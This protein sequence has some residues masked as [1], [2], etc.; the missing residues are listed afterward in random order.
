MDATIKNKISRKIIVLTCIALGV[1]A[2]IL[3]DYEHLSQDALA[4]IICLLFAT[5]TATDTLC[6]LKTEKIYSS[7]LAI[8]KQEQPILFIFVLTGTII[9]L[10]FSF[11]GAIYFASKI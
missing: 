2:F 4:I 11:L 5:I 3:K 10:V 6:A 8:E 7:G 1:I 9:I